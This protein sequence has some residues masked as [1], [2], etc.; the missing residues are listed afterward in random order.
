MGNLRDVLDNILN[1]EPLSPGAIDRR[2][3]DELATIALKC[4]SKDRSRRYQSSGE[5]ARDLRRHLAGEPIEAKRD[6]S[7]YLLKKTMQRYRLASFLAVGLLLVVVASTV[8]LSLMYLNAASA[9]R[10]SERQRLRA[11]SAVQRSAEIAVFL[12]QEQSVR[13][14]FASGTPRQE[15]LE[16]LAHWAQAV[17]TELADQPDLAAEFHTTVGLGYLKAGIYEPAEGHLERALSLRQQSGAPPEQLAQSWHDLGRARFHCSRL[18]DAVDCYR[19]RTS[20]SPRAL[21]RAEQ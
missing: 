11:G 13:D 9:R 3:D 17:E 19:Q 1:A 16:E 7:L 5:L 4:L 12:L 6:S 21:R 15:L 2:V 14:P 10:E 18:E 8:A 20:S